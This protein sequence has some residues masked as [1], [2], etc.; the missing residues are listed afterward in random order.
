M[1]V[2]H[3]LK[4]LIFAVPLAGVAWKWLRNH[5]DR[6]LPTTLESPGAVLDDR[7]IAQLIREGKKLE[8]LKAIRQKQ[9]CGLREAQQRLQRIKA[10]SG[11]AR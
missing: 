4:V 7:A 11:S 6:T 8:A 9:R 10:Q 3:I 1:Q 2:G 5:N